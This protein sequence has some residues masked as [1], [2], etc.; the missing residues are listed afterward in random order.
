MKLVLIWMA[1]VSAVTFIV[2]AAD[3]RAA[4]KRRSR[5]REKT[6]LTLALIGGALGELV[7]MY[8]CRHKT[9]KAKFSVGVPLILLVQIALL[10]YFFVVK[11]MTL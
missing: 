9:K 10:L 11:E 5:V 1:A 3:K 4:V 6:L 8:L 7:A 2:T